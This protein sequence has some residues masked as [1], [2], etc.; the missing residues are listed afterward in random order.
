M[1]I[2]GSLVF[3]VEHRIAVNQEIVGLQPIMVINFTP[4]IRV[5][6]YDQHNELVADL[7]ND[8]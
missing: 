6:A 2:R 3:S 7:I 5:L 4:T 8:K 1:I